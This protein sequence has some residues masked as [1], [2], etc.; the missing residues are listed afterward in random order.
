MVDQNRNI[1]SGKAKDGNKTKRGRFRVETVTEQN[2][3]VIDADGKQNWSGTPLPNPS[4]N[5]HIVGLPRVKRIKKS[6]AK[7]SSRSKFH[8]RKY[9]RTQTTNELYG[10]F[11]SNPQAGHFTQYSTP[12]MMN[13]YGQPVPFYHYGHYNVDPYVDLVPNMNLDNPDNKMSRTVQWVTNGGMQDY[14]SK[15]QNTKSNRRLLPYHD[16]QIYSHNRMPYDAY[17][18]GNVYYI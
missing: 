10:T 5:M 11:H 12:H 6:R 18:S 17:D 7:R 15:G 9:S 4:P 2:N 13:E 3:N 16:P 1:K 8:G 14:Y